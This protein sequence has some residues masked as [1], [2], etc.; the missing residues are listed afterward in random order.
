MCQSVLKIYI[1][2]FNSSLKALKT[3]F[4]EA[5]SVLIHLKDSLHYLQVTFKLHLMCQSVLKILSCPLIRQLK[6]LKQ[7]LLKL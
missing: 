7:S 3:V 1:L 5:L 4:T 2:S 6:L